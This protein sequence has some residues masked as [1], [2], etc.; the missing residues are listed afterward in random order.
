M[1]E[2]A[3]TLQILS[4]LHLEKRD[5]AYDHVLVPTAHCLALLGDIGSPLLPNLEQ[6]I[7]WCSQRWLYVLYIP[8][9]HEYYNTQ[10]LDA[11]TM[12][13]A[14]R[15]ICAKF[16]NVILLHN[17]TFTVGKYVFIGTT[18]WSYIPPAVTPLI[19]NVVQDYMYIYTPLRTPITPTD[20][21]TE[22]TNNVRWLEETV[23][24][25]RNVGCIPVVLTHHTPSFHETIPLKHKGSIT[26]H[27]YCTKLA[28]LPGTI[29]LW[30][31]GHTHRNFHHHMEGYELISNQFGAGF[32]PVEGYVKNMS[33][34][35]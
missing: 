18:L 25:V 3:L 6:F 12:L 5:I 27:A 1:H 16:N 11:P 28:C 32:E 22:F 29:R 34:T 30:C 35:L 13:A 23:M 20:I 9:N 15:D 21:T 2:Q 10:A 24:K 26:S 33:I 8:G 31:C 7:R 14:L 4:D 19:Q 17:D